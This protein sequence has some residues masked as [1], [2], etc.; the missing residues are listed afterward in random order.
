VY[1]MLHR[2]YGVYDE[3]QLRTFVRANHPR[4][5]NLNRIRRGDILTLPA[6]P[7]R[8]NPLPPNRHWVVV[9]TK[10]TLGEA[11]DLIRQY[12]GGGDGVRLFP[13]WNRQEGLVF[14]VLVRQGFADETAADACIRRLP[15][16]F[17]SGARVISRWSE[18]TNYYA[19]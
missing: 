19:R 13:Y 14:A 5:E 15:P 18:G 7:T 17:S 2:I 10:N 8:E 12:P 9:T 6:V 3:T 4:L 11:Y 1:T 16:D